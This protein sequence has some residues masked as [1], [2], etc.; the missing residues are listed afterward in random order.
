MACQRI[1]HIGDPLLPALLYETRKGVYDASE[2]G[3]SFSMELVDCFVLV[4]HNE[5]RF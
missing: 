1:L 5:V 4:L 3:V 2:F